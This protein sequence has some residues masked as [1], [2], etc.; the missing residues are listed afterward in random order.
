MPN[1]LGATAGN[2][3]KDQLPPRQLDNKE[4]ANNGKIYTTTK[5]DHGASP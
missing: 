3:S 5:I 2:A 4:F 1:R